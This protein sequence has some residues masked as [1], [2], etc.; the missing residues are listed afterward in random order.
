[1]NWELSTPWR[2]RLTL[3]VFAIPVALMLAQF[4][5]NGIIYTF[6][7][8]E[9]WC[10]FY[11]GQNLL[12][13]PPDRAYF[14]TEDPVFPGEQPAGP[15]VYTHNPWLLPR[16]ACALLLAVGVHNL[17]YQNLI[18]CLM[19][20]AV[21]ALAVWRLLR[22][23]G[24]VV[25]LFLFLL[26]TEY[27]GYF[28]AAFNLGRAWTFPMFFLCMLAMCRP[29]RWY[30]TLAFVSFFVLWQFE[31]TFGVFT[32][33]TA[34]LLLCIRAAQDVDSR[35]RWR[36]SALYALLGSAASIAC[37]V[38]QLLLWYGPEGLWT[39]LTVT[40]H[41]RN[42]HVIETE[43]Q[44]F[45]EL[46][47]YYERRFR[48]W[49]LPA[50]V[51][52]TWRHAAALV[53]AHYGPV[54]GAVVLLGCCHALWLVIGPH[55]PRAR[56]G[57]FLNGLLTA[58]GVECRLLA[59]LLVAGMGGFLI[60]G[61][62]LRGETYMINLFHYHPMLIFLVAPAA[63]LGIVGLCRTLAAVAPRLQVPRL[64]TAAVA[65]APLLCLTLW[66]QATAETFDKYRQLDGRMWWT[67]M[68]PRFRGQKIIIS[69]EYIGTEHI[70]LVIWNLTGR[71]PT[72]VPDPILVEATPGSDEPEYVLHI[73]HWFWQTDLCS[74]FRETMESLGHKQVARGRRF[75][76]FE[77]QRPDGR[78]SK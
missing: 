23:L 29:G 11:Q 5:W 66:L 39:D 75:A 25:L 2:R 17:V 61:V 27:L 62:V 15:K 59:A 13:Q 10:A 69:G 3:F 65:L 38:G 56:R 34:L 21:Y 41:A 24:A 77:L 44:P 78:A 6:S 8:S 54:I 45:A 67:L 50:D 73:D 12:N 55:M 60:V 16:V 76:I 49:S 71:C 37:F 22:P 14:L 68:E 43:A 48:V 35:A 32:T 18:I 46:L 9:I 53:A 19:L 42:N 63:A 52:Q 47:D 31:V 33:A 4:A 26:H 28:R 58:A 51:F 74:R 36:A 30:R 40:L 1:M 64:R 72:W 57:A 7:E 70:A 20:Y